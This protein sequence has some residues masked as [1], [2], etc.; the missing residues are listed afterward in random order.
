MRKGTLTLLAMGRT[1]T[2]L[3]ASGRSYEGK[4]RPANNSAKLSRHYSAGSFCH[5][6]GCC[7]IFALSETHQPIKGSLHASHEPLSV[8]CH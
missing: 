8:S 5:R 3:P 7:W 6:C 1:Q 4:N 2:P